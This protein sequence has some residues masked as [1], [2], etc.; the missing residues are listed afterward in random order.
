M[1]LE[2]LHPIAQ[3]PDTM[4][5]IAYEDRF[6]DIEFELPIHARDGDGGMVAHHLCAHHRQR[7]A[8]RRVH[9]P[10]HDTAARL[11]LRQLQLPQP[12]PRPGAQIPDILRDLEEAGGE[13]IELAA[14]LDH[15][16]VGGEGFEFVVRAREGEVR[17]PCDFRGDAR[18]ETGAGVQARS[19]GRAALGE[20][21]EGGKGGFDAGDGFGELGAVA[22]EFLAEG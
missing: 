10:R 19:D 11:I 2:T 4:Q 1:I 15:G 16:V 5:Q 3:K 7:L 9:F 12:A 14:A 21:V 18:G 6:E 13:G 20:L 22:A 17:D 8:L